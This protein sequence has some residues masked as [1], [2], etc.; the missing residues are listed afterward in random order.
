MWLEVG[1]HLRLALPVVGCRRILL[2]PRV[3]LQQRL[4]RRVPLQQRIARKAV[5]QQII[6]RP[7]MQHSPLARPVLLQQGLARQAVLFSSRLH[8]RQRHVRDRITVCLTL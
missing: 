2:A 3:L 6:A 5:P 7:V 1:V 4:A 8:G